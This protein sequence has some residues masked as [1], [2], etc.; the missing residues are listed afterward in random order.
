MKIFVTGGAGYVGSIFL[1]KLTEAGHDAIVFD[2]LVQGHRAAFVPGVTFVHGDLADRDALDGVFRMH[3]ID[4]VVHFAGETLVGESMT[5]P[6]LYFRKI[7]VYGLHLLETMRSNG[8]RNI[9]FSSTSAVYGEPHE[10]PIQEEAA[11]EPLNA[12][13]EAKHIFERILHWY[14]FAHGF[15]YAALRYFNAAGATERNGEDHDPETHLIPL[16]LKVALGQR[17]CIHIFGT[18]YDTPDGTCIRSYTHVV[19]LASAHVLALENLDRIGSR[20][21][22]LGCRKGYSVHEVIEAARVVTGRDIPAIPTK[23]RPGDPSCLIASA[24]LI[25]RELGWE[26]EFPDIHS[27]I[28]TAWDWHRRHPYG[29]GEE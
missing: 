14:D 18:D 22:N 16:V 12:Y 9:V 27:I 4:G 17:E 28:Q 26:P 29:Y 5:N 3:K 11:K 21:Y 8:V 25:R 13:G 20:C 24:E 6:Y 2:N 1:E 10:V 23:R 15:R 7:V 19:D